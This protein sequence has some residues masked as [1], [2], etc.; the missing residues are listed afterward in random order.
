MNVT[1]CIWT[2]CPQHK[3]PS[4]LAPKIMKFQAWLEQCCIS[5]ICN[6]EGK[7]KYLTS[8][9]LWKIIYIVCLF[10]SLPTHQSPSYS[11]I[12]W[13]PRHH[14]PADFMRNSLW[15]HQ[16]LQTN[17]LWPPGRE[18][19]VQECHPA[20][21]PHHAAV[22][23]RQGHHQA[24]PRLPGKHPRETRGLRPAPQIMIVKD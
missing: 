13:S 8:I 22:P 5:S 19:A 2:L 3:R 6:W 17:S 15:Q 21:K 23:S 9:I 1:P 14:E 16:R 12:Q 7:W 18:G 24:Q 4:D 20:H 11:R 10:F